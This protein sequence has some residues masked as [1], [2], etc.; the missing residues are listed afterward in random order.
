MMMKKNAPSIDYAAW[1]AAYR[2]RIVPRIY[3][4]FAK[5]GQ[6]RH[7]AERHMDGLCFEHP[8]V[9]MRRLAAN[10]KLKTASPPGS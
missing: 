6:T 1:E 8:A 9:A 4:A 2:A 7:D 10:A 5:R 3:E